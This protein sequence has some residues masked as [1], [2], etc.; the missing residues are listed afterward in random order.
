MKDKARQKFIETQLALVAVVAIIIV[1][2]GRQK[3]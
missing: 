1:Y 3:L 2:K